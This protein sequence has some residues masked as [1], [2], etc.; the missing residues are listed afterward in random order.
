MCIYEYINKNSENIF[1]CESESYNEHGEK[2]VS[3]MQGEWP[4]N[5]QHLIE[6]PNCVQIWKSLEGD[7]RNEIDYITISKRFRNAVFYY[8]TYPSTDWQRDHLPVMCKLAKKLQK[9][10]KLKAMPKPQCNKLQCDSICK[11][12]YSFKV[13]NKYETL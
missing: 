3:L 4:Y 6:H 13:M 2:G 1:K 10:M 8:K 9:L 11:H 5:D 7:I 12:P